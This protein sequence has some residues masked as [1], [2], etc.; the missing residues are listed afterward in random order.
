[1]DIFR[2][3]SPEETAIFT[4]ELR[5][6]QIS[7]A[8]TRVPRI[9]HRGQHETPRFLK[10]QRFLLLQRAHG[11]DGFELPVKRG[12]AHV[13][14]IGHLFDIDGLVEMCP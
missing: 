2:R 5:R 9:Q 4:A 13:H 8:T 10:P 11:R 1:M 14:Q 7:N 12:D 6:A 3:R